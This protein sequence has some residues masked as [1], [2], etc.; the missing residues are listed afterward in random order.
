M[1][2]P[3]TLGAL[4]VFAAAVAA[5]T[6]YADAPRYDYL[7][8][9]YASFNDPSN[10]GLSSDHGY[11]LDGS[12]AFSDNIIGMASYGH[13][14]ADVNAFGSSGTTSGNDYS[15]GLGYRFALSDS[16][17]L[18]PNISYVHTSQS[19]DAPGLALS[20]PSSN[21]GYDAGVLLRAMVTPAMEL[22]ANVDHSTPGSS[23]NDIGVAGLYNFTRSFAVGLGYDSATSQGQTSGSWSVALRYYFK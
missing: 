19:L 11:G 10:S 5:S 21:S 23:S 6:A 18:V 9:S 4:V 7:D 3:K 12:Y 8:L 22:D 13:E 1:K 14:K 20:G 17:D 15:A 2:T 16:L